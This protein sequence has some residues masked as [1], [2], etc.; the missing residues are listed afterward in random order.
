MTVRVRYAPS[1]TGSP[2]VGNLRTA[3]YNWLLARKT[4]GVFIARLED[5]DRDPE[6]YRPEAIAEIEESLRFLGMEPDEWWVSGGPYG[7]YVQSQRLHLYRDAAEELIAKGMAYRCYCTEERLQ[8]MRRRQQQQGLP[9]GYDRRCRR[10]TP[11]ERARYEAQGL[12]SVVRL[13]VPLDGTTAY[14]DEVYG[15]VKVENR[16]VDDQVLLKSNGWPTYHLAEVVDDHAQQITHVIRGEDWMP[17]TPKHVMLF[18]AFGWPEPKWVHVPLILGKD[19]KKL[20]K[21]HGSTQFLDFVRAG[22]L[23]EALI[24]FLALLGWSAG[25]ENRE[26]FSVHELIERFSLEGISKHPAVFDYDKLRW[27]NGEYIRSAPP[28]QLLQRCIPFLQAHGWVSAPPSQEEEAYAAKVIPLVADRMKTLSEVGELA[29]FFFCD[30]DVP[31]EK[32]RRKWL[33]DARAIAILAEAVSRMEQLPQDFTPAD[34]EDAVNRIASALNLERA[35]VIHTLRVAVTGRT[36]G[37]GLFDTLAALGRER[38]LRRLQR[39]REWVQPQ[40]AEASLPP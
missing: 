16:T 22:Y 31:E 38:I 18:R 24:N 5:T 23:P 32:G 39:A 13:A 9:T 27:M 28:Q 35:P 14:H 25:E 7:P 36:V 20:S 37:P 10:L 21:R 1:P 26:L 12:P 34:A 4:G 17:S 29:G 3:I 15:D 11:D 19:R 8:E 2:H 30:P 6:R 40:D 33:A